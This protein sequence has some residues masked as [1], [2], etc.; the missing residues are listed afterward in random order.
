MVLQVGK[1][2]REDYLAQ[3]ETE[4]RARFRERVHHTLEIPTYIAIG[5]G[6]LP[7]Q[8]LANGIRDLVEIWKEKGLSTDEPDF[9]WGTRVLQ[10]ADR[11]NAG[12]SIDLAEFAPRPISE[13]EYHVFE[14]IVKERRSVRKWTDE[15]VPQWKIDKLLEAGL[16]AAH[17]CNLQSIRYIVV[18]EQLLPGYFTS[19]VTPGPVHIAILQDERV[20]RANPHNPERNHLLDVGAAAQNIVLAAH[21]LGLGAVWLTHH[22]GMAERLGAHFELPA[23]I[24][25]VTFITL[26]VPAQT[27]APVDRLSIKETLLHN[28]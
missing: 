19:D 22:D 17:S 20:Y 24:T 4:F 28:V 26:G 3:D 9:L 27:P 2:T 21:A 10:F 5:G 7:S 1:V 23:H 6:K 25:W 15:E 11:L 14:H 13:Q 12:E 8:R 16:W 18:H